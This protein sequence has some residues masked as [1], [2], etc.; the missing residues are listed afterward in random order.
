MVEFP[1]GQRPAVWPGNQRFFRHQ[2]NQS[3]QS[4]IPNIGHCWDLLG[5]TGT[6]RPTR[7]PSITIACLVLLPAALF[8][9]FAT[10]YC[11]PP[12]SDDWPNHPFS[13]KS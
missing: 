3:E 13:G 4:Q 12:E 9:V 6:N 5:M 2:A 10:P 8:L 1:E 7:G 11:L